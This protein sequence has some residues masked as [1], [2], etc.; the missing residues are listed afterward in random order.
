MVICNDVDLIDPTNT[1]PEIGDYIPN[2]IYINREANKKG[3]GGGGGRGSQTNEEDDEIKF[4]SDWIK[5]NTMIGM[6]VGQKQGDVYIKAAQ[7]VA[8]INDD[9][10]TNILLQ[11]DTIDID[12]L[13]VKLYTKDLQCNNLNVNGTAYLSDTDVDGNLTC[14]TGYIY[15]ATVKADALQVGSNFTGA[16]WQSYSARFCSL[17]TSNT[18]QDTNGI[19]HVGRLVTSYSD[20]TIYYLGHT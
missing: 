13:I 12:G 4:A 1:Q 2:I 10:G 3:G 16:T 5:T 20:T 7:I 17:S 18:F 14:D 11:A 6:V 19:N 9:G 15:G 8:S